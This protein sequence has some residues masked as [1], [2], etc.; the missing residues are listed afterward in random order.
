MRN[1]IRLFDYIFYRAYCFF[2]RKNPGDV[3]W[4]NAVHILM[5]IQFGIIFD[6]ALVAGRLD[7]IPF[8][9]S[10]VLKLVVIALLMGSNYVRYRRK[11]IIEDDY[12]LFRERWY[13]EDKSTRRFRGWLMFIVPFVMYVGAVAAM[14]LTSDR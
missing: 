5:V 12:R 1:L 13:S 6:I 4:M 2:K 9:G 8:R 3:P 10:G 14:I 7:L 11:H